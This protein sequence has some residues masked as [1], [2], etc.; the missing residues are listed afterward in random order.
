MSAA[1]ISIEE[2]RI[3]QVLPQG[4]AS[5]ECK[6]ALVKLGVALKQHAYEFTTVTPLTHKRVNERASAALAHDLPAI[7]GWNRPFRYAVPGPYI[8]DLM[9]AAGVVDGDAGEGMQRATVRASTLGGQLYFHSSWPTTASDSVFFGPDTYRFVRELRRALPAL[10]SSVRRAVD[11]GCGAGPA[12]IAIA[13]ACPEATV[14]AADI[15]PAALVLAE[16]NARIA[17]AGNVVT[18]NSNMLN[19]VDGQFDLIVA[20]PPYLVDSEQRTYRHGGGDLGA[21]FSLAVVSAAIERLAPGGTLLLYTGVAMISS[22][23]PFRVK[24]EPRLREAGFEWT[25]EEIDPDIF[26]EELDTDAYA[27][28]DRIAAVWLRATAP[29]AA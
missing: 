27:G 19:N 18:V 23:D 5:D 10:A 16:V 29:G 17:G 26:G 3:E 8:L 28:A 11:I 12:A 7:F 14:F 22:A 24:F 1:V 2:H 6:A 20:N 13:L 25:Y 15:N 4:A 9:R 21:A